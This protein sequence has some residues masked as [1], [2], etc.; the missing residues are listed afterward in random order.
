VTVLAAV[1]VKR[2]FVAKRRLAPLLDRPTRSRLGR[3]LA[4]HTIA[5]IAATGTEV[6]VLAA[7][8]AVAEWAGRHGWPARID[9]V[10]GLDGAA[11][12]LAEHAAGRGRPWLVV[13]ADLPLLT[14][15]DLTPALDALQSG[16]SPLAPTDDGGTSLVGGHGPLAFA[17]GAASFRRHLGRLPRPRVVVRLGLALDLDDPG[18]FLAAAAHPR[19]AWLAEY[20][21]R[22]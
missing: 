4:A 15:A 12:N 6:V 8:P 1:A 11:A 19:G 7:D 10:G 14:V 9:G 13:H 20:P 22:Q 18:D 2:F 5:T 17:Y 3:A 21:A 16:A